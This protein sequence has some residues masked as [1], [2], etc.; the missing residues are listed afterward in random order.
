MIR[1]IAAGVFL[2]LITACQKTGAPED[3]KQLAGVLSGDTKGTAATNPL[4]KLF[5]ADEV[6][7]YSGKKLPAGRNAAMGSGCQWADLNSDDN[8]QVLIQAVPMEYADNPSGAPGFRELPDLGKGAYVA[9]DM[10]GWSAGAPQGGD[11]VGIIVAGPNANEKVAIALMQET[12]K[13]RK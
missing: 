2:V 5:S 7:A 4:C 12:L 3:A 6:S 1:Y 10:G 9:A 13:R 11:F 8:A